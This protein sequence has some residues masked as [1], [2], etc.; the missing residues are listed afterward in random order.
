MENS[1]LFCYWLDQ[2][3]KFKNIISKFEA[4]KKRAKTKKSG[5]VNEEWMNELFEICKCKSKI[6]ENTQAF[7]GE[8]ACDCPWEDRILEIEGPFLIDQRS[9][10]KLMSELWP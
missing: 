10:R 7:N 6:A 8:L 9:V 2:N 4:V 3:T 5:E 1:K